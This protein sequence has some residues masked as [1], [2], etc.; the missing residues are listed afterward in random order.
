MVGCCGM[1]GLMNAEREKQR[2]VLH[3][4]H[5]KINLGKIKGHRYTSLARKKIRDSD[6]QTRELGIPWCGQLQTLQVYGS[7]TGQSKRHFLEEEG[8]NAVDKRRQIV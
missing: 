8:E 2:R 7:V 3:Q 5:G 6:L 1:G 4:N